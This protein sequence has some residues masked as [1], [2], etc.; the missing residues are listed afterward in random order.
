[1]NSNSFKMKRSKR[2]VSVFTKLH[3]NLCFVRIFISDYNVD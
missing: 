1:M 2:P 3:A